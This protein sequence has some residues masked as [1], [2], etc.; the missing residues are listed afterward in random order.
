MTIIRPFLAIFWAPTYISFIKRRFRRSFWGAE[1]V[2]IFTGQRIMTQ[3]AYFSVSGFI[4]FCKKKL[5][6]MM[7]SFLFKSWWTAM[8]KCHLKLSFLISISF[9]WIKEKNISRN[10]VF[11]RLQSKDGWK[12]LK[13][14][15]IVIRNLV[16]DWTSSCGKS[17]WAMKPCEVLKWINYMIFILNIMFS[18]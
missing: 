16:Q 15:E 12:R 1:Q 2:C 9:I 17:K 6:K 5:V 3:N 10:L 13:K 11:T 4:R 14:M 8:L 7:Q 18:T